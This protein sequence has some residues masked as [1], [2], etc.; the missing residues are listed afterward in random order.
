M[1]VEVNFINTYGPLNSALRINAQADPGDDCHDY[2]IE[3]IA[4]ATANE[5]TPT[6]TARLANAACRIR[7]QKGPVEEVG[8]NGVSMGSLLAVVMDRLERLQAGP[9][10][11][12]E[13]QHALGLIM[14]AADFLESRT[15]SIE[16]VKE[17]SDR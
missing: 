12:G 7:F 9:N 17:L 1:A 11:C 8:V 6:V 15:R 5:S 10:A 14:S 13:N 4:L 3:P 16:R 2:R